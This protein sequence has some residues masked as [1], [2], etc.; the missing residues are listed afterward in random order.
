MRIFRAGL[1]VLCGV[2]VSIAQQNA[3]SSQVPASPGVST[4]VKPA[5][6]AEITLPP[7]ELSPKQVEWL[8]KSMADWADLNR[9]REDDAQLPKP[10]PGEQRVVFLGD[11]ITDSWGRR[12]GKFF[13]GKPYINRGI[14][15][16]VTPQ[17]LVRFQQDVLALQPSVVVILAGINDIAGN[18]GPETLPQIEDN[19]RSM[20]ALAKANHVRVVLSSVLPAKLFPWRRDVDPRE[21]VIALNKWLQSYAAEQQLVFLNYYPSL[22]ESDGGMRPELAE[23]KYIHPNDAGYAVMEPLAEAAIEEA[24]KRPQP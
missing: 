3:S 15:G 6:A 2:S 18:Y 10:A 20:V 9:Y 23:D 7:S 24:L 21:E 14:S 1:L 19:F 8:Q 12:H 22:A 13:P 11:S 16:Q 5:A 17:M 4:M